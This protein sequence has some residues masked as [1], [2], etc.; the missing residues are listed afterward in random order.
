MKKSIL[1]SSNQQTCLPDTLNKFNRL[2]SVMDSPLKGNIVSFILDDQEH[3][4]GYDM[5]SNNLNGIF[6]GPSHPCTWYSNGKDL[7]SEEHLKNGNVV[8]RLF[9]QLHANRKSDKLLEGVLNGVDIS[10]KTMNY[11]TSSLYVTLC[12]NEQIQW[13]TWANEVN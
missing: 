9:R 5:L 1:F 6:Y 11:Y 7:Y 10:T 8:R 4:I 13:I 12:G 2:Y 3:I